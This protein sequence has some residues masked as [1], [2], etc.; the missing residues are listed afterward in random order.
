MRDSIAGRFNFKVIIQSIHVMAAWVRSFCCS[1]YIWANPYFR[2]FRN[3][4]HGAGPFPERPGVASGLVAGFAV[5]LE[6]S[7]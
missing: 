7:V 5:W 1:R 4:Y 6:G 3:C 2:F